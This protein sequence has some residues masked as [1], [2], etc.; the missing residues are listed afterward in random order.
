[1]PSKECRKRHRTLPFC[2]VRDV[3]VVAS[4]RRGVSQG[5]VTSAPPKVLLRALKVQ[6]PLAGPWLRRLVFMPACACPA[7]LSGRWSPSG[8]A[9]TWPCPFVAC[10]S[11][12]G[13]GVTWG[14]LAHS[15]PRQ[16]LL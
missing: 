4:F 2:T 9:L 14:E 6:T 10:H 7:G 11:A 12:R 3:E 16:F 13:Q 1:M 5:D 15:S 8:G